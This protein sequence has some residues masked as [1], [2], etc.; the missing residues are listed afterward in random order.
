MKAF[1]LVNIHTQ[2]R[3]TIYGRNVDRA[4]EKHPELDAEIWEV[5]LVDY[6]D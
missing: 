4:F 3:K 1:Y 2:E 6:I 5:V